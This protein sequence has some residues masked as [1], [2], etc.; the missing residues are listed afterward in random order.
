MSFR[1]E[2]PLSEAPPPYYAQREVP[3]PEGVVLSEERAFI[4]TCV[5]E[6]FDIPGNNFRLDLDRENSIYASSTHTVETA[7]VNA[8]IDAAQRTAARERDRIAKAKSRAVPKETKGFKTAVPRYLQAMIDLEH[9]LNDRLAALQR[10]YYAQ[11]SYG[12]SAWQHSKNV[13]DLVTLRIENRRLS[14]ARE[15]RALWLRRC[16]EYGRVWMEVRE[17]AIPTLN[18]VGTSGYKARCKELKQNTRA[19]QK[20]ALW[21]CKRGVGSEGG[22]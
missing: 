21:E 1:A 14:R 22:F 2:S 3:I 17:A 5:R 4:N 9:E 12:C 15:S 18:G 8:T 16:L 7:E 19:M 20:V 13:A 10:E 11:D 6:A